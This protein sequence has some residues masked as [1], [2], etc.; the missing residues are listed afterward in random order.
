[1]SATPTSDSTAHPTAPA[2]AAESAAVVPSTTE[3]LNQAK[4]ARD[5]AVASH[6]AL[7]EFLSA[8]S[9]ELLVPLN[10][11]VGSVR[12][13]QDNSRESASGQ[14]SRRVREAAEELT[15]ALKDL[16]DFSALETDRYKTWSMRFE[17]AELV[18][19]VIE[20]YSLRA[21]QRGVEFAVDIAP[22]VPSFLHTDP[23]VLREVFS[24][25]LDHA[26]YATDHGEIGLEVELRD[27]DERD[28]CLYCT[29]L[30]SGHHLPLQDSTDVFH[31]FATAPRTAPGNPVQSGLALALAARLIERLGGA[32]WYE[33]LSPTSGAFHFALWVE[34]ADPPPHGSV[35]TNGQP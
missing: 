12:L 20:P 34:R 8:F 7:L 13:L 26:T 19:S 6:Q 25:L 32:L 23:V 24:H 28:V 2:G 33:R 18:R 29:L 30:L 1:M 17:L 9:R 3:A 4:A 31:P 14:A 10:S 21:R 35:P 27:T 15:G 5:T 16:H 11:I 22:E